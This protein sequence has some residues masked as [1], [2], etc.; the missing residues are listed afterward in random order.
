MPAHHSAMENLGRRSHGVFFPILIATKNLLILSHAKSPTAREES[1]PIVEIDIALHPSHAALFRG[2]SSPVWKTKGKGLVLS[3]QPINRTTER[4]RAL[5]SVGSSL[6]SLPLNS[7]SAK[8]FG[9]SVQRP[10]WKDK[11]TGMT[12]KIERAAKS[13]GC[14]KLEEFVIFRPLRGPRENKGRRGGDG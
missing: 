1:D 3:S 2:K 5:T 11:V 9:S 8:Q 6:S 12:R 4:E 13:R 14:C 10:I 7:F